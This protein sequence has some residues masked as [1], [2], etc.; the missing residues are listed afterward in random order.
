[1]KI[2]VAIT[3]KDR[4]PVF[5]RTLTQWRRALPDGAVLVVVDDSSKVPVPAVPGVRVIRHDKARGVP[6]AKNAS[7]AALMDADVDHLFLSD[8]DC[9]PMVKQWWQPYVDD[10]EPHLLHAWGNGRFLRGVDGHYTIWRHPRGV[11]LY[12]ERAVIDKVGGMR[13]EFAPVMGAEHVEWS[14]RMHNMGLT[15][16]PYTGLVVAGRRFWCAE[17]ERGR[18]RSSMPRSRY[19]DNRMRLRREA[20]YIQYRE[21]TGFVPYRTQHDPQT[22]MTEK[23]DAMPYA[24]PYLA[25]QAEFW[26]ILR[27]HRDKTG[28]PINGPMAT[29]EASAPIREWLPTMLAKYQ[30]KSM[31]DAPCGDLLWMRHVNLDGIDYQGFDVEPELIARNQKLMPQ[32][33]FRC[34]NLLTVRNIPKVDVI[35]CRD[36]M[37]HLPDVMINRV[38]DKFKASGSH[39]LAA[40]NFPNDS[41]GVPATPAV[42]C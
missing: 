33:T 3:T 24:D 20:I 28:A 36:F 32:C 13:E 21:S 7:I 9:Y 16:W 42:I 25:D 11:M 30:I 26:T 15:R 6:G 37:L 31:L 1:M 29:L 23:G 22:T 8:D 41:N 17:D 4:R 2:G 12:V 19:T 38:L 10:P 5:N 18:V 14:D 34:V 39:Y 40:T 35:L 27:E